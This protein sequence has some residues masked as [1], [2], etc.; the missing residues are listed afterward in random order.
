MFDWFGAILGLGIAAVVTVV[1]GVTVGGTLLLVAVFVTLLFALVALA[2][3]LPVVIPVAWLILIVGLP[4][5]L[6]TRANRRAASVQR[7]VTMPV[8][9]AS[10]GDSGHAVVAQARAATPIVSA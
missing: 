3:L 7:P 4:L 8:T 9:A 1:V 5:V 10:P 2:M 6:I